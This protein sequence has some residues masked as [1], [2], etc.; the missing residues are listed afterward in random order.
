M[1]VMSNSPQH[2]YTLY[3]SI[4]GAILLQHLNDDDGCFNIR[5][6]QSDYTKWVIG[7]SAC[8]HQIIKQ[9]VKK[10]VRLPS[11]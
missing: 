4:R 5:N 6:S 8:G 3:M 7:T 11:K 10:I 1:S 2:E 9:Y